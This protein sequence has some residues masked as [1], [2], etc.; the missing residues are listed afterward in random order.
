MT[1]EQLA[2][3]NQ[4]R[5]EILARATMHHEQLV[6]A[7]VIQFV[8]LMFLVWLNHH[9]VNWASTELF[10][11]A[12]PMVFAG[13]TYNYQANQ[14]TLESAAKY[15]HHQYNSVGLKWDEFFGSQKSKQHLVSFSKAL[16][17]IWPQFVPI[18]IWIVFGWPTG[19]LSSALMTVDLILLIVTLLNFR[20]KAAWLFK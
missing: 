1:P 10:L 14:C 9:Q 6:Y 4:L 11:L 20:Y 8:S 18:V 12:L 2:E 3:Y 13:L 19:R 17:L 5:Q 7:V 15:L 16:P